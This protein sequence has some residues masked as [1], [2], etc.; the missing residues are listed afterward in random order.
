MKKEEVGNIINFLASQKNELLLID[1]LHRL[2]YVASN[3]ASLIKNYPHENIKDLVKYGY[4]VSNVIDKK[5]IEESD[6]FIDAV[7]VDK[8]SKYIEDIFKIK[9]SAVISQLVERNIIELDDSHME[10]AC[11]YLNFDIIKYLVIRG[12]KLKKNNIMQIFKLT[13]NIKQKKHVRLWRRR[14]QQRTNILSVKYPENYQSNIIELIALV[15]DL[16]DNKL[17]KCHKNIATIMVYNKCYELLERLKLWGAKTHRINQDV[18]CVIVDRYIKND[19]I[20]G[21]KK[22]VKNNIINI[23]QKTIN[24]PSMRQNMEMAVRQKST[25]IIEYFNELHIK[26]PDRIL[27]KLNI[28]ILKI[29]DSIKYPLD[30]TVLNSACDRCDFRSMQFLIE[31]KKIQPTFGN[32]MT[33]LCNNAVVTRNY[34]ESKIIGLEK[35]KHIIDKIIDKKNSDAQSWKRRRSRYRRKEIRNGAELK[36]VKYI[37]EKFTKDKTPTEKKIIMKDMISNKSVSKAIEYGNAELLK[38][39]IKTF[40]IV[41]ENNSIAPVE[42]LLSNL[43]WRKN[44][45][46]SA[47]IVLKKIDVPLTHEQ[48]MAMLNDRVLENNKCQK[49]VKLFIEKFKLVFTDEEK[50]HMSEKTECRLFEK[51]LDGNLN[52]SDVMLG[53]LLRNSPR[54]IH[55]LYKKHGDTF[56]LTQFL[57]K[58]MFNTLIV[59]TANSR[60]LV[61]IWTKLMKQ[62]ITPYAIELILSNRN[63]IDAWYSQK[64]LHDLIKNCGT[65][66]KKIKEVVKKCF[67]FNASKYNY[68]EQYDPSEDEIVDNLVVYGNSDADIDLLVARC[69]ANI[70]N[71]DYHDDENYDRNNENNGEHDE[72]DDAIKHAEKNNTGDLETDDEINSQISSDNSETDTI[73][74]DPADDSE[75]EIDE[76]DI[77]DKDVKIK[78]K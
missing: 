7:G 55:F 43:S 9:N 49:L 61:D 27:R 68:I 8:I 37:I 19:D 12:I 57:T 18:L 46:G 77:D 65:V 1:F 20:E 17:L 30:N 23:N 53:T 36:I 54:K 32:Y 25:K 31:V 29:L 66:T 63:N 78:H 16:L 47:L 26:C 42:K 48:M 10:L 59:H 71:N 14:S 13:K 5:K 60:H 50:I 69:R 58:K 45:I 62:K 38:Y 28:N 64:T 39:I 67:K 40:K 15:P 22:L 33:V 21:Y 72:V 3:K 4:D 76:N 41:L 35:T 11:K 70:R 51:L 75:I 73:V 2:G 24:S 56:P 44:D 74:E 34:L 6:D 52:M